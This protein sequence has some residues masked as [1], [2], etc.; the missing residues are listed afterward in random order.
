MF[1]NFHLGFTLSSTQISRTPYI[2]LLDN[3][4]DTMDQNKHLYILQYRSRNQGRAIWLSGSGLW[5]CCERS[6]VQFPV[7]PK[8][9]FPSLLAQLLHLI[10][11]AGAVDDK[12]PAVSSNQGNAW[13]CLYITLGIMGEQCCTLTDLPMLNNKKSKKTN[14]QTDKP[15]KTKSRGSGFRS[16]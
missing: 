2:N 13:L 4:C 3:F 6:P 15:N 14:K 7:E 11:G 16:W 5:L 9:L 12:R 1:C 10:C 8:N